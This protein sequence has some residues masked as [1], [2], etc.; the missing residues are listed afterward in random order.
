VGTNARPEAVWWRACLFASAFVTILVVQACGDSSSPTQPTQPTQST[1][2]DADVAGTWQGTIRS[3]ENAWPEFRLVLTQN[4]TSVSGT[5]SCS[6][7]GCTIPNGTV[8]GTVTGSLFS[9]RVVFQ[10]GECHTF[11]GTQSGQAMSGNYAC[12]GTPFENDSGTWSAARTSS[13]CVPGLVTP[14]DNAVLDNGRSD[15]MDAISWDFDWSDCPGAAEYHLFVIGSK[16]V[17][18]VEDQTGITQSSFSTHTPCAYIGEQNRF[19]WRW[20]VRAKTGEF[21]GDWS[22]ERVFNVEP[23]DTDA[24]QLQPC[25]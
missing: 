6:S 21:W 12:T 19:D 20:R 11:N 7:F 13:L 1:Q 2:P 8:S 22:T 24:V 3:Y 15:R 9:G 23:L 4:G 25:G 17:I 10:A 16:A 18:P 5:F 14:A